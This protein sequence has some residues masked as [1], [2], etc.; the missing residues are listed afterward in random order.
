MGFSL[1][2]VVLDDAAAGSVRLNPDAP[3]THAYHVAV[4]LSEHDIRDVI[5]NWAAI[6]HGDRSI[7]DGADSLPS[8]EPEVP[9]VIGHLIA[10]R[11]STD[12]PTPN[13]PYLTPNA[14]V[15]IPHA[16]GCLWLRQQ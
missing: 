13:H 8:A 15:I 3:G 14:H 2:D 9:K 16:L 4:E 12:I 10:S 1:D 6:T 5:A 11:S 7:A